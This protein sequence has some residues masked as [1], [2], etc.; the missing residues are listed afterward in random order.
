MLVAYLPASGILFQADFTLPGADQAPNASVVTLGE[1]VERLGLEFDRYYGVH[2][3]AVPV[4]R[5]DFD[6]VLARQE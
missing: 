2:P 1:N 6:A 5:A 4:T 3:S